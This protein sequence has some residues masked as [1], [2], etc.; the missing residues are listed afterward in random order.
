M[1]FGALSCALSCA[2]GKKNTWQ[3]GCY[4]RPWAD[5]DLGVALDAIAEAG[6][7]YVGLMTTNSESRLVISHATTLDEAA[8]IGEEVKKRGL[9]AASCYGGGIPVNESLQAGIEGM[10]RLIDN[11]AASGVKNLLM[12]GTGD[13]KLYDS[14]YRAIAEC[15]D[16][17]EEAGVGISIKPHGGLNATGPQCRKTVELVDHDNFRIWYDA[18]NIY[19]YSDAHLDPI[20]DA[21][22]VDGLVTGLCVKDYQH[23]KNVNVTPGTGMVNFPAV[24]ARL[25][26]GGFI[27]GPLIVECL[28]PGDLEAT[29]AEAKKA[30]QFLLD[31]TASF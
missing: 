17:A 18:G 29:L 21:A 11:C 12:G 30:R 3:I 2:S 1:K 15:C 24:F 8:R 22:T 5:Y 10:K 19:Y 27:G 26:Q 23:P 28:A 9:S 14:Y 16:Y 4:T 31:L 13:E 7:K 6:Y 25:R 20:D